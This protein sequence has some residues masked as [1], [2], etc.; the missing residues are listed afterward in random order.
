MSTPSPLRAYV[1]ELVGT[2]LFVTA[3]LAASLSGGDLAPLAAGAALAAVVFAGAGVSG[4][5]VNP[6]VT[7][8]AVLRRRLPVVDLAPYLAAQLLGA[9]LA[10]LV[11]VGMYGD[12]L[13]AVPG[14]L[15]VGDALVAVLLVETV[16]TFALTWVMLPP[17][18]SASPVVDGGPAAA[19][20]PAGLIFT[21]GA[22][23]AGPV[24]GGALNPAL[25]FGLALAGIVPWAWLP[26]YAA[27]QLVGASLAAA[28]SLA[29]AER[30]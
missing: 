23:V 21:T 1:V 2:W 7:V 17:T 12:A 20:L 3:A 13:A 19:W 25:A 9:L 10:Y 4:S 28:A 16:F 26:V 11:V 27:A 30:H 22:V 14:P 15:D 18:R 8:A 24:S 6:A 29:T 5:Y